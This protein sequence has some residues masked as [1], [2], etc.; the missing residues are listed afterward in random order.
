[1]VSTSSSPTMVG[2]DG[3]LDVLL[4]LERSARS[5]SPRAVVIGGEAGIGK[6]RLVREF[7]ARVEA[8]AVICVGECVDLGSVSVPFAPVRGIVRALWDRFGADGIAAA[9]G[10]GMSRLLALLPASVF[11]DRPIPK[12]DFEYPDRL[13]DSVL[14]LLE[15]FGDDNTLVLVLEDV[16]WVDPATLSLMRYLL[17]SLRRGRILVVITY[18]SEDLGPHH[19]LRPVLAELDRGR[20]VTRLELQRLDRGQIRDQVHR[21][22]EHDLTASELDDLVER[23]SGVPF[24]IEEL[25][26]L[27]TG[28]LPETLRQLL[29]VRYHG[30]DE[31]TRR[32]LRM[33]AAGGSSVDHDVLAAVHA[34]DPPPLNSAALDDAA[35]AA[36][37]AQLVVTSTDSYRFRHAL[38]QE[39]VDGELVPGERLRLHARY[40]EVLSALRPRDTAEI[41]EHWRAAGKPDLAFTATLRAVDDARVSFAHGNV[42]Q[43]SE[44]LIELWPHVTN[45]RELSGRSRAEILFAAGQSWIDAGD[46]DRATA[47]L[48]RALAEC[49]KDEARLRAEILARQAGSAFDSSP[50]L[51]RELAERGLVLLADDEDARDQ[52]VRARLLALVGNADVLIGDAEAG[53][54]TIEQAVELALRS[55]GRE[56][57]GY[58]SIQ[59]GMARNLQGDE[60]GAIDTFRQAEPLTATN[61]T[62]LLRLGV[63]FNDAL[64][65]MGR[66]EEAVAV[67]ED[68]L[69]RARAF[70]LERSFG[71]F[72]LAN[73][74]DDELAL[75]H[76][77]RA[78]EYGATALA[79]VG[80]RGFEAYILRRLA[81]LALWRDEPD[82]VGRA[83]ERV[84]SLDVLES[85]LEERAGWGAVLAE[86]EL[87]RG[88]LEGAWR[89]LDVLREEGT[90]ITPHDRIPL[91]V[92][93]AR[94]VATRQ[95]HAPSAEDDEDERLL[96]ALWDDIPLTDS[97]RRWQ[98]EFE[99]DLAGEGAS[100][101]PRWVAAVAA[102]DDPVMP[103]HALP[104]ARYRLASVELATGDRTGAV[105]HLAQAREAAVELGASLLVRHIDGLVARAHLE[106]G[107]GASRERGSDELTRREQQ[108][109]Q[110]VA[111]GLSNGQIGQRLFI[112]TKTV[113]VHVS[114]ILRK[115]G[116]SSRTEAAV[117]AQGPRD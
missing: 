30:L 101:V 27:P 78:A 74:C 114:A 61:P 51:C 80:N 53:I 112:S 59:L 17:R 14:E 54:A 47:L 66:F 31:G 69:K 83:W 42:G 60:E 71:T 68:Y 85:D 49:G 92:V 18:R 111:E 116:V 58:A 24:L 77:D 38:L 45:P 72:L 88:D 46:D 67:G 39:A 22:T 25:V 95:L 115:L 103:R 21:I 41:A 76:W 2:R 3:E 79:T 63:T 35:T 37:A 36:V 104:A 23:S 33:L 105:G 48:E 7:V 90:A 106:V 10:P 99:A 9:A 12:A 16:H 28:S 100:A 82:E 43:L 97:A 87:E 44:R 107:D 29:L 113:S 89:R 73:L 19:P 65:R 64:H 93:G 91:L 56:A 86:Y 1:M 20:G 50:A 81:W 102:A 32:F 8:D 11:P 15:T 84:L 57:A 75:G 4:E 108:V 94:I 98:L 62:L 110:L 52:E 13:N 70:G 117:R 26:A 6:S 5:G 96:R 40:A 55:G 34:G 109:L